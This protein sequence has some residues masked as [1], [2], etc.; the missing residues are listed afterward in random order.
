MFL[1]SVFFEC[2]IKKKIFT[3]NTQNKQRISRSVVKL[4]GRDASR[5]NCLFDFARKQNKKETEREKKIDSRSNERC[6][7]PI[8]RQAQCGNIR[9][10]SIVV[11]VPKKETLLFSRARPKRK[12]W[13]SPAERAWSISVFYTYTFPELKSS[14]LIL[15]KFP[16]FFAISSLKKSNLRFA[17]SNFFIVYKVERK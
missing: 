5:F 17:F 9:A 15:R 8:P 4:K 12:R 10:G 6:R 7:Q 11:R 14:H 2:A 1:C 3:E 13:K 16:N